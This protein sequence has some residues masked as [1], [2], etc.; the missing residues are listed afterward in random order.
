MPFIQQK[1]GLLK[2]KILAA[3]LVIIVFAIPLVWYFG[4]IRI[5]SP[6]TEPKQTGSVESKIELLD[7][8]STE[9]T[10]RETSENVNLVNDPFFSSLKVFGEDIR[11]SGGLSSE[12]PGVPEIPVLKGRDNPFLPY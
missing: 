7:V 3:V 10:I 8:Q 4:L 1:S 11:K 2:E 6:S 9:I 5:P 12:S